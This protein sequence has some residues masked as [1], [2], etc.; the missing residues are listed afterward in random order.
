MIQQF[1]MVNVDYLHLNCSKLFSTGTTKH[2]E[3]SWK[4]MVSVFQFF[5]NHE[6]ELES[7]NEENN[8]GSGKSGGR[9]NRG[10]AANFSNKNEIVKHHNKGSVPSDLFCWSKDKSVSSCEQAAVSE[11][12]ET[13]SDPKS[14][15]NHEKDGMNNY[16]EATQEKSENSENVSEEQDHETSKKEEKSNDRPEDGPDLELSTETQEPTTETQEPTTETKEPTTETQ[17][18]TTE[19]QEPTT[20][21]TQEP[22]IETQKPTIETQEPTTETQEPTTETQEP[23]TETQEPTTETQ[24]PTT[25]ET[26][27]PTTETQEPTIETQEPTT[28]TQ[29]PTTETQEPTTETQEPTTETQE[30]TTETQEPTTETQE[31]TTE[32]AS[33]VVQP[34]GRD[35]RI[36][37]TFIGSTP[38][39][40]SQTP[41]S[42]EITN[43]TNQED[44]SL[45][46][47]DV[48]NNDSAE[49][50]ETNAEDE[51]RTAGDP[52]DTS[53]S[54]G[55]RKVVV[56]AWEAK[57]IK[58][59]DASF[60]TDKHEENVGP[61]LVEEK[62]DETSNL[63]PLGNIPVVITNVK[64]IAG[65][66]SSV[67][68]K[69]TPP[70]NT[71]GA[72]IEHTED[73]ER[74]EIKGKTNKD[75]LSDGVQSSNTERPNSNNVHEPVNSEDAPSTALSDK[76]GENN[77]INI[78]DKKSDV[79]NSLES[80]RSV[81]EEK[82]MKENG[83]S[84]GIITDKHEENV[85][86]KSED[87]HTNEELPIG[88]SKKENVVDE[89]LKDDSP[90]TNGDT[91]VKTT[92][93]SSSKSEKE[94]SV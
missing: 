47:N 76:H 40:A 42:D 78:T 4:A 92:D 69:E 55:V 77:E 59:N 27:E 85:E 45:E 26:Q 60:D 72:I 18:P 2:E 11:G 7:P 30:P 53:N 84:S 3:T 46:N 43:T 58:R 31:P 5:K 28:E 81:E 88:N 33:D 90:A 50:T 89:K 13:S 38:S 71:G 24:E 23:T 63:E 1:A 65:T 21:E 73:S 57:D 56:K 44:G 37:T 14:G 41:T 66:A 8:E 15:K 87:L 9:Q 83:A 39:G 35:G 80:T 22:I 62:S 64:S 19:T 79:T 75:E 49:Q 32:T 25:T 74:E 20:T 68:K 61:N 48:T 82:D 86:M 67:N 29:E 91:Q 17:E 51:K 16:A 6:L 10:V 54:E 36:D 70:S 12:K 94:T 34:T 52:G 93:D